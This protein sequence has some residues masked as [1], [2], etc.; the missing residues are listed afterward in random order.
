[1]IRLD[2][3]VA[4][5]ERQGQG[6][7]A[8]SLRALFGMAG[9]VEGSVIASEKHQ[10]RRS[11]VMTKIVARAIMGAIVTLAPSWA[12]PTASP[13]ERFEELVRAEMK[14]ERM[15]MAVAVDLSQTR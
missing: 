11:K 8:P 14:D 3:E 13:A 7:P 6:V 15:G 9:T 4:G 12:Q 10:E 1:V 5:L 2:A